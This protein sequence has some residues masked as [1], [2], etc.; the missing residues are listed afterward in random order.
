MGRLSLLDLSKSPDRSI[1]ARYN[2]FSGN[3]TISYTKGS[4]ANIDVATALAMDC[5]ASRIAIGGRERETT[6]LD[7]DSGTV[8]WKAKNIKPDLQTLL[9]H[10]IWTTALDFVS[11]SNGGSGVE[12]GGSNNLL[13][14]GTAYKQFRIYDV[15]VSSGAA[16]QRRPILCT[17]EGVLSHRV[18]ALCQLDGYGYVVGDAAGDMHAVDLRNLDKGTVGR[19][20]GPGGSIRRIQRHPTLPVLACVSLD[21]MMRTF[22]TRNRKMLDCIYLK[23]R[24]SSMIFCDDGS[25]SVDAPEGDDVST[26]NG[27][28]GDINEADEIQDYINSDD[29]SGDD[30]DDAVADMRGGEVFEGGEVDSDEDDASTSSDENDGLDDEISEEEDVFAAASNSTASK[31]GRGGASFRKKKKRR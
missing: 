21:R 13:A 27:Q 31:R 30:D 10:P 24:L 11:S 6:L 29:E 23:Q 4:F 16:Q 22:D 3:K 17:K 7:V 8:L 25:W 20:A 5:N 18:T 19:F 12:I 26:M 14:V 2:A 9:Q 1:V 28:E 15:R